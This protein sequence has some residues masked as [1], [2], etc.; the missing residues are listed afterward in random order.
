MESFTSKIDLLN[1]CNCYLFLQ[2]PTPILWHCSVAKIFFFESRC[3]SFR[4]DRTART[5]YTLRLILTA[6]DF[7]ISDGY[8]I[9]LLSS[10]TYWATSL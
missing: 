3:N 1:S 2:V 7:S 5:S 8:W 9:Y 10:M 4:D 6:A